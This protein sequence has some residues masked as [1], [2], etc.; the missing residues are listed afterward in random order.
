LNKVKHSVWLEATFQCVRLF[1][2]RQPTSTNQSTRI[3]W[4]SDKSSR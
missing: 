2:S 4:P 3:C 1:L